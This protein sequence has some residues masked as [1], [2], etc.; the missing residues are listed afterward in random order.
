M[1]KVAQKLRYNLEPPLEKLGQYS[2][3]D[4]GQGHQKGRYVQTKEDAKAL[5]QYLSQHS[6]VLPYYKRL[7][8][9]QQESYPFMIQITNVH[10]TVPI[11][12]EVCCKKVLT[13][14]TCYLMNLFTHIM[15]QY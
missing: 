10:L 7:L 5:V 2:Y 11:V 3:Q 14:F 9:P 1:H 13:S 12:P 15:I 6:V 4:Q 8:L